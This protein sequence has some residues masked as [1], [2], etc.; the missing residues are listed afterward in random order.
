MLAPEMRDMATSVA[1]R[2][3]HLPSFSP[4][5]CPIVVLIRI[6]YHFLLF[7]RNTA[8]AGESTCIRVDQSA[9]LFGDILSSVTVSQNILFCN[10]SSGIPCMQILST[11]SIVVDCDAS[12]EVTA[13][14]KG[15][16]QSIA[17]RSFTCSLHLSPHGP[18]LN[19]ARCPISDLR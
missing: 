19:A 2:M 5:Y 17:T 10:R 11:S 8:L 7:R 16:V 18:L 4:F 14:C 6:S 13:L 12:K 1:F 9:A 3:E 15:L